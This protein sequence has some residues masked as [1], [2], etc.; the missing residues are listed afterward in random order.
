MCDSL[1]SDVNVA[2]FWESKKKKFRVDRAF[3]FVFSWSE[4]GNYELRPLGECSIN[5]NIFDCFY[6]C[7]Y[8]LK[9]AS[10]CNVV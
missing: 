7:V 3:F 8:M 1:G 5:A 4:V 6:L 10:L 2:E 9:L